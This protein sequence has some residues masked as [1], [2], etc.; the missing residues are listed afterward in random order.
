MSLLT[1]NY[2]TPTGR[3]EAWRFT[4][5]NRLLGLHDGTSTNGPR[6]SLSLKGTLPTGVSA[7]RVS[8]ELVSAHTYSDDAITQRVQS[9]ADDVFLVEISANVTVADPIYLNRTSQGMDSAEFSRVRINVGLHSQATIIVENTGDSILAE[10]VEIVLSAGSSLNFITLQEWSSRSVHAARHLASVGTDATFKSITVTV[11]GSLVRLLP[12]VEF[13]GPGS[14]AELLGVYF[15]TEGQHLE[16]R[17]HVDH[18]VPKAKSRV[19]FKGALAGDKAHTV[20]IGDVY[21]RAAAEGTDTYELNRNLLLSDGARA[22]SVPNL[23]IETGEIVG[24]GHASTTGRF[25]DEQLF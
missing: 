21:I 10:D 3:E 7:S 13:S 17:M 9:E 12:R 1:T 6:K 4:P 14:S 11:G 23:E 16:H 2:L 20:W 22:D 19:N 25:D 18:G 15:A 8:R 5:L 24:A